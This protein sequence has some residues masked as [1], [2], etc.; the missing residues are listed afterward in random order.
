VPPDIAF[1]P[2]PTLGWQLIQ[3]VRQAGPLRCRWVTCDE[4]FGR[5]TDFLDRVAA[6]G[7]WY[8]AEVPHDTQVWRQRPAT[9][10]PTWSGQGRKPTRT[11]VLA[12]DTKPAEVA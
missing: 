10:V 12:G 4:A 9:A 2:K 6:L 11:R 5:D 8:F 7:L 1:K 3:A